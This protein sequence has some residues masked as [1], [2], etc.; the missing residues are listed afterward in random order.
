MRRYMRRGM[1][2]REKR[3]LLLFLVCAALIALAVTAMTQL[4]PILTSLATARVS[5]A[6][7]RVVNTSVNETLYDAGVDYDRLISLEK[8]NEGHI[9]AVKSNMAEF[10]RLQSAVL[11]D[12]LQRL[13]EVST[14]E[15]A[16]PLGSLTG[17]PLLAG[18]GPLLH[19]KMQSVGSS[20]AHFENAFASAGINQTRHRILIEVHAGFRILTPFGGED[21]EIISTYPVTDTVIVGT[22]PER[23]AYISGSGSDLLGEIRDYDSEK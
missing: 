18:R 21:R 13:S 6:V 9:T 16:I 14:R 7:T 23:Y 22:V 5:N 8:D 11:A 12:V 10:N 17:S 15:L 2:G 20:S 19:I 3:R 1:T 4:R